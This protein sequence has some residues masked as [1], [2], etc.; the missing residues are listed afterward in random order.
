V[1]GNVVT[2]LTPD[3]AAAITK[4]SVDTI[5]AKCKSGELHATKPAGQWRIHEDSLADWLRACEPEP[6]VIEPTRAR[7]TGREGS[8]RILMGGAE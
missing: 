3:E 2:F 4:L 5:R 6:G 1:G 7:V 8:L